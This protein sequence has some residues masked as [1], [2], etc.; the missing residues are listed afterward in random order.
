MLDEH[1]T[2]VYEYLL[3]STSIPNDTLEWL[4][5]K[6]WKQEPYKTTG[7]ILDGF[8]Q[9]VEDLQFLVTS[10]YFFDYAIFLTTEADEVVSRLLPPRLEIWR[11]LMAKKA[12]NAAKLMEWKTAKKVSS[13]R[14]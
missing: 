8:P 14:N 5:G 11:K 3:N 4:L 13:M 12:E 9:S 2:N 10:N 6:F 7:F 1:E